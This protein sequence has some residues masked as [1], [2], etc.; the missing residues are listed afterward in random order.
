[1]SKSESNDGAGGGR[2]QT[3]RSLA[4]GLRTEPTNPLSAK[5]GLAQSR[6]MISRRPVSCTA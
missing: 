2:R 1:M 5:P 6:P 3:N 4:L